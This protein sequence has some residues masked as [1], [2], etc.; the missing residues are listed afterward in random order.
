[1]HHGVKKEATVILLDSPKKPSG[2]E[3][4]GSLMVLRSSG[5]G[6]MVGDAR[7]AH[8]SGDMATQP[9]LPRFMAIESL[10]STGGRRGYHARCGTDVD[11]IA[12][13]ALGARSSD[14]PGEQVIR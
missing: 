13:T 8:C 14:R 3:M 4:G 7:L 6:G 12:T 5:P 9:L 1:M 11:A 2:P 10:T